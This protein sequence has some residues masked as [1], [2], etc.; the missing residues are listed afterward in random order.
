MPTIDPRLG[1]W[2][3][4]VAKSKFSPVLVAFMKQAPPKEETIVYREL[5]TDEFEM[6]VAGTQTDGK[7]IAGKTT[8]PR[9]GGLVKIQQ[10]PF[11]E[12][13]TI[14]TTRIDSNK[15]YVTVMLNGKQVLVGQNAVSKS[16]KQMTTTIKG[17]DP[18]G[19]PFEQVTVFDKQ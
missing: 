9:Q 19:K 17:A 18:Q 7:P 3:L 6:T 15:S 10:G 12:G 11:P 13:T 4:N 16:G 14:V 1:T 2:K 8:S 5:G